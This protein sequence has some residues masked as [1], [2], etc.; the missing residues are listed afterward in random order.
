MILINERLP[1]FKMDVGQTDENGRIEITELDAILALKASGFIE[2]E[3]S[4][5]VKAP[6]VVKEKVV[7]AAD[8]VEDADPVE[9][10]AEEKFKEEIK[11]KEAKA[12]APHWKNKNK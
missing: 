4:A 9:P 1:N 10:T 3:K 7:A 12:A 2:G 11:P 6:K 5:K 8:P